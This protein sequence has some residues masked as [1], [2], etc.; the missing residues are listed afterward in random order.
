MDVDGPI[1]IEGMESQFACGVTPESVGVRFDNCGR[2]TTAQ[3]QS[4][5]MRLKY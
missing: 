4:V 3:V 5:D 1:K 2:P